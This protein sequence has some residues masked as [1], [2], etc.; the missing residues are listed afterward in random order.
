ML[1]YIS[2]GFSYSKKSDH[3]HAIADY[4]EAIRLD[5]ENPALY[6]DRARAYRAIGDEPHASEDERKAQG[7]RR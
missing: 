4:S 7:L 3:A 1:S 5:P 2:R 6:E